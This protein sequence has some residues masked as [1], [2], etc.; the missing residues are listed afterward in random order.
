MAPRFTPQQ[1]FYDFATPQF[2]GL[3]GTLW[4]FLALPNSQPYWLQTGS[5]VTEPASVCVCVCV[6]ARAHAYVREKES[7]R[8]R[9]TDRQRD[10]PWD[11]AKGSWLALSFSDLTTGLFSPVD[12]IQVIVDRNVSLPSQQHWLFKHLFS[13]QQANLWCL[14]REYLSSHLPSSPPCGQATQG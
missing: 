6:H 9:Q 7:E 1:R 12:L 11:K 10:L 3:S 14:S 8:E 5:G 4:T 2:L 13:L